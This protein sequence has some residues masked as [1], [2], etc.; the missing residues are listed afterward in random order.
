ME[1]RTYAKGY[2]VKTDEDA[3]EG[4]MAADLQSIAELEN[5]IQCMRNDLCSL[6]KMEQECDKSISQVYQQSLLVARNKIN[7]ANNRIEV[8]VVTRRPATDSRRRTGRK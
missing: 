8:A 4:D 1:A 7:V 5:R 2:P 6:S 3:S